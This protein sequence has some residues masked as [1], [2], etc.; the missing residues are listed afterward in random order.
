MVQPQIYFSL[1]LLAGCSVKPKLPFEG[2]ADLRVQGVTR[3]ACLEAVDLNKDG[4]LD[5]VTLSGEI[6]KLVAFLKDGSGYRKAAEM[7]AGASASDAKVGDFNEDDRIDVAVSHHGTNEVWIFFGKGTGAFQQPSK[8]TMPAGKPHAHMLL[9]HDFNGDRHTDLLIAQSDDNQV[10]LLLGDGKGRFT[11]SAGSPVKTDIHPY[12]VTAADFNGDGKLDFATP[13]WYGK[14]VSVK[15][16]D[17]KG[18]FTEAPKSPIKGYTG[19][20]AVASGDLTG[21][22]RMDLAV[23]NDDSTV[24]HLLAGDG[25]GS[26]TKLVD[27][28]AKEDCFAP[29]L[30]DLNGDGKL[31]VIATAS[32]SADTFS[33]WLN[34][35]RGKFGPTHTLPCRSLATRICIADLNSDGRVDLAIGTWDGAEIH[36]WFGKH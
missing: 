14:S 30:V 24:V 2:E 31:D 1:L 13:N 28:R 11:P 4:K 34:L 20:T 10:W 5:L 35:G 18:R 8:A 29:I 17:G 21:D 19:P 36:I 23:A 25:K 3:A 15:L 9:P 26:F 32:N 7:D 27:L 22:R 12:V 33:Y 6:P 16:G